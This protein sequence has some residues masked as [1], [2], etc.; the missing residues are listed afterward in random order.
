MV[1]VKLAPVLLETEETTGIPVGV[2]SV[3][4]KV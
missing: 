1:M 4:T 2:S 3:Q